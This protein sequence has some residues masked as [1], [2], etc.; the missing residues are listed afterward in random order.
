MER[1]RLCAP[2]NVLVK[3]FFHLKLEILVLTSRVYKWGTIYGL[4]TTLRPTGIDFA[5]LQRSAKLTG[6]KAEAGSVGCT[7]NA[8]DG[9]MAS[10]SII[11]SLKSRSRQGSYCR[12]SGYAPLERFFPRAVAVSASL[13][14]CS[15]DAIVAR[16]PGPTH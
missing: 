10:Q 11:D 5:G 3:R 4:K 9:Q 14:Q 8:R 1:L 2:K 6:G 15:S 13:G 7:T 12:R 16:Q